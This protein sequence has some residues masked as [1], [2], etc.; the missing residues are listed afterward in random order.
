MLSQEEPR[1]AA[2]KFDTASCGF[3]ATARLLVGLCLQTAVNAGL[4]SKVSEEVA[5]I[6]R[7][8]QKMSSTTTP[9]S[10][11]VPH[12]GTLA[13]MHAYLILLKLESSSAYIL[14]LIVSSFKFFL[15]APK[16]IF[17]CKSAFRPFEVIQGHNNCKGVDCST[18]SHTV[19]TMYCRHQYGWYSVN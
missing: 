5:T 19:Y 3:P 2:V 4:F 12:R 13:N 18:I 6:R 15:C 14:P 9:L 7:N 10:F 16:T 17:F 11:D 8:S 1:D